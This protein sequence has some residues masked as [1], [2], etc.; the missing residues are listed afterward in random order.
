MNGR[1]AFIANIARPNRAD[2]R[3]S[4]IKAWL[5]ILAEVENQ[6]WQPGW[7]IIDKEIH[8]RLT[9]RVMYSETL[10]H[11]CP[12]LADFVAEVS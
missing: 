12:L 4:E 1:F 2:F 7:L 11:G 10:D 6:W 3:L 8:T 5:A 9:S